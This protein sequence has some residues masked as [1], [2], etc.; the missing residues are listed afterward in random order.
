MKVFIGWDWR[1]ETAY[2]ICKASLEARASIPVTVEKLHD[3]GLRKAG[4]YWREHWVDRDGQMWD[5]R[6]G[7]P[8][9]TMFSFA[10]FGIPP[11]LDYADEWVMFM[12][13]DMLWR[14]DI[15][16]LVALIEPGKAVM[17]VQHDHRPPESKK[18][19]GVRQQLYPRKN[20]SSVMLLNPSRCRGLTKYELNNATGSYLHA[21]LWVP[22]SDIGA[23]PE[24]WNW[25]CGWSPPKVDPKIVHFTRG[26]PDMAGH[27]GEPY[28][29]EWRSYE[30]RT[31]GQ[32]H[33]DPAEHALDE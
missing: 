9:S 26:T 15:A 7:K 2:R 1:D 20:W 27:E 22:E 11:L 5:A 4:V 31:L 17:C 3:Y 30:G 19:D 24:E 13:A 32:A 14:A 16:E 6:D 25:L 10:R 28:A 21:L 8:F 23:L 33:H 29:D 12:D 18:M